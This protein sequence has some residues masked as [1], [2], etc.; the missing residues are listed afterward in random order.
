MTNRLR[1]H[2]LGIPSRTRLY[3]DPIPRLRKQKNR[4]RESQKHILIYGKGHFLRFYTILTRCKL[5]FLGLQK[6]YFL[7]LFFFVPFFTTLR[8]LVVCAKR[9]KKNATLLLPI[10]LNL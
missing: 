9:R 10:A 3:I 4:T 1:C 7:L 2:S 8:D 5:L 6:K